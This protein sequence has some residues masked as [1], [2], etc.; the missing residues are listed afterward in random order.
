MIMFEI[1]KNLKTYEFT[2][3]KRHH[4]EPLDTDLKDFLT[5]N[6]FTKQTVCQDCGF[7]LELKLDDND[8]DI[9]W[10]DEI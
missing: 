9:Y 2:C 3:K 10:I 1:L 8:P 7:S 4:H 5:N 6:K